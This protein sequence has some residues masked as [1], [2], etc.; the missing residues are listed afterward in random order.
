MRKMQ[1]CLNE[2][3]KKRCYSGNKL[4]WVKYF[5][6]ETTSERKRW[7]MIVLYEGGDLSECQRQN[8]NSNK[9]VI[10]LIIKRGENSFQTHEN[11]QFCISCIDLGKVGEKKSKSQQKTGENLSHFSDQE[12]V[13][14]FVMWSLFDEQF[15]AH[16][17]CFDSKLHRLVFWFRVRFQQKGESLV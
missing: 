2:T 8:N 10:G 7:K 16:S 5:Y 3:E 6:R 17:F 4:W 15:H 11:S 9:K 12:S 1:V 14:L 13:E